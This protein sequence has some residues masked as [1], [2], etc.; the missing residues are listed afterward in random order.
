MDFIRTNT[1]VNSGPDLCSQW[2]PEG[3]E[4]NFVIASKGKTKVHSFSS[5]YIYQGD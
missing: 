2:A 3:K 4:W 5:Y 1:T